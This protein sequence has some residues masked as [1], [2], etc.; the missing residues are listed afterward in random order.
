[1]CIYVYIYREREKDRHR[2]REVGPG[3][4]PG[5]A[6]PD[7]TINKTWCFAD[8]SEHRPGSA[9]TERCRHGHMAAWGWRL[10]GGAGLQVQERCS[11]RGGGIRV[12]LLPGLLC[13]FS[14]LSC[15]EPNLF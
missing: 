7:N 14:F 1:M 3:L 4:I 11:P 5:A 8:V 6:L 12:R 13:C 10:P 9:I 2:D 15:S